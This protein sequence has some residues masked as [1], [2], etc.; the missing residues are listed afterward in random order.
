MPIEQLCYRRRQHSIGGFVQGAVSA[1]HEYSPGPLSHRVTD[2][3]RAVTR[4]PGLHHHHFA[5]RL[6]RGGG[7]LVREARCPPVARSRVDEEQRAQATGVLSLM[8]W[9]ERV[10]IEPTGATVG[11]SVAVLKTGQATRPD[12]PPDVGCK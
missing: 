3:L 10:G 8:E 1:Q 2:L 5:P 9:R 12:P 4:S 11:V 7:G 6:A